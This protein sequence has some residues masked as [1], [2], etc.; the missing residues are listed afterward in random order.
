MIAPEQARRVRLLALDVDGVLTDNGIWVAPVDGDRV[1]FKRFDIQDGLGLVLLR[2][3]GIEVAWVSGRHSEATELRA[4]ELRIPMLIQD[5]GARKLPAMEKLLAEKGLAWEEVAY[6]GDDIADLPVLRR[7][8]LPIS[9][10]NGCPEVQESA[11]F[12]TTARGG[13]GAVREVIVTLLKARG[14]WNG[15]IQRYLKGCGDPAA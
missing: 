3:S 6:V 10:A 7:A 12:V 2:G 14:E 4:K 15:A 8:G 1:E 9:V 13:S 11:A 5:S